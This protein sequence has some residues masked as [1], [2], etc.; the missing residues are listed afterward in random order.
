MSLIEVII[1]IVE[2]KHIDDR[3]ALL[4]FVQLNKP[5]FKFI[6]LTNHVLSHL[7][8][9]IICFFFYISG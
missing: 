7:K 2:I 4:I 5:Q 3:T 1:R 8:C 6:H 9:L